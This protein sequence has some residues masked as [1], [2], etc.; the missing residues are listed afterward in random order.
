M[1]LDI[2]PWDLV[3]VIAGK[4]QGRIGKVIDIRYNRCHRDTLLYTLV[5]EA[6][7]ETFKTVGTNLKLLDERTLKA[8]R[9]E[10]EIQPATA[11]GIAAARGVSVEE[12]IRGYEI[13]KRQSV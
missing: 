9:S 10:Q 2:E 6:T 13:H 11:G 8:A 1:K 12:I 3:S 5:D 4:N 7:Q